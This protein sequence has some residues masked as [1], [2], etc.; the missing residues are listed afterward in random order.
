MRKSF[1]LLF[2]MLSI[3]TLYTQQYRLLVGGY[4]NNQKEGIHYLNID[5]NSL[6]YK[7]VALNNNLINPSFL[8][9]DEKQQFVYAI[10]EAGEGTITSF[11][12]DSDKTNIE[13]LNTQST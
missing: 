4:T 2:I 12:F 6:K 1:S 8:A 9:I 7:V 13:K 3:A 11:S 5:I 10:G